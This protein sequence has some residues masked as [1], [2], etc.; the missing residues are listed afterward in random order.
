ME[1]SL[2]KRLSDQFKKLGDDRIKNLKKK[3]ANI[4]KLPLKEKIDAK[5]TLSTLIQTHKKA[6]IEMFKIGM[7]LDKRKKF[8]MK[9]EKEAERLRKKLDNIIW[10][11]AIKRS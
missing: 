5:K 1:I 2:K 3:Y 4:D 9:N 10:K 8:M 11:S 7:V 6:D